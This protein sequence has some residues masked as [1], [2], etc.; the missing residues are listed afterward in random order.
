MWALYQKAGRWSKPPSAYFPDLVDEWA[1][2]QFDAAVNY[3]GLVVE[4]AMLETT[5]VGVGDSKRSIAKYTL[6][7]LLDD[8]FRLPRAGADAGDDAFDT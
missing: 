7:Q 8:E 1:V 2:Y 6:A 4:N 5:E 3:L